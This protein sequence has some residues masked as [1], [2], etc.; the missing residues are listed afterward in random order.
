[1]S[2][3]TNKK[4]IEDD[5]MK[6]YFFY[7]N[8]KENFTTFTPHDSYYEQENLCTI[9]SRPDSPYS[10]KLGAVV[11][12]DTI[13]KKS[14][15]NSKYLT[16]N[17]PLILRIQ[18]I[19]EP[20]EL[21]PIILL[22]G[23][24]DKDGKN[25][26]WDPIEDEIPGIIARNGGKRK[27]VQKA[28]EEIVLQRYGRIVNIIFQFDDISASMKSGYKS[29]IRISFDVSKGFTYSALGNDAKYFQ[30][31]QPTMNFSR[32]NVGDVLHEFGHALGLAHEHQSPMADIKWNLDPLD[33]NSLYSYYFTNFNWGKSVVDTQ[34]LKKEDTKKV[35]S[36]E[37]DRD[38]IMLYFYPA[39]VTTD[40]K[41]TNENQRLSPT[42][43]LHLNN[44][45]PFT[46]KLGMPY[47]PEYMLADLMDKYSR[48]YP[49]YT[50]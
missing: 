31:D 8:V 45:Y 27:G 48:M 28:I 47:E 6:N 13:W 23:L 25:I 49:D 1:M 36:S 32:L 44:I 19:Q 33:P 22:K 11:V 29:D 37:F 40:G 2:K 46:D 30:Q 12:K 20:D 5:Y 18:F 9:I 35:N 16:P 15:T 41:G 34:I 3:Y 26:I 39:S 7:P 38:S 4:K 24:K 42:D 14:D 10:G 17:I 43:V 21:F 50:A